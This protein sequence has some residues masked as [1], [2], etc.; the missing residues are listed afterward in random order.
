M[1]GDPYDYK[2]FVDMIKYKLPTSEVVDFHNLEHNF[3]LVGSMEDPDTRR[4]CSKALTESLG[5][6]KYHFSLKLSDIVFD[7]TKGTEKLEESRKSWIQSTQ[8][9]IS[10]VGKKIGATTQEYGKKIE[11]T[12]DPKQKK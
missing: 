9:T 6:M 2:A 10:D 7:V 1:Q 8:D 3:L 11:E 5:F 4:G 12:S